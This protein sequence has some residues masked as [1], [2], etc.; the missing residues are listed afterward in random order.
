[1][2]PHKVTAAVLLGLIGVTGLAACDTGGTPSRGAAAPPPA[3][4]P[5]VPKAPSAPAASVPATTAPGTTECVHSPSALV[6]RA[7]GLAVGKV[8]A[9]AEGPVTVC[10]Y[11]GRYEVMVRYQA[12]ENAGQFAQD[13]RSVAKLRQ[14]VSSV[15]GLGDEAYFA[16]YTASRPASHTLATRKDGLAVFITSPASLSAERAL[17]AELLGKI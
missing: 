11:T 1:M 12:G 4:S 17:M 5:A 10:A 6:G 3:T 15:G 2:S 14:S 13:R 8:V 9:S 16:S 7:L